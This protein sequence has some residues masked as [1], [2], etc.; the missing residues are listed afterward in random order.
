MSEADRRF[1]VERGNLMSQIR[2][3]AGREF[4]PDR[5][6]VEKSI[7]VEAAHFDDRVYQ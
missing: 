6:P 7:L 4:A 5:H 1:P 3:D 2:H